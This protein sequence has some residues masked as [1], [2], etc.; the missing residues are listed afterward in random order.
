MSDFQSSEQVGQEIQPF[1]GT[2]QQDVGA[3]QPTQVP[4]AMS[5]SAPA[6]PSKSAVA[7][8][9]SQPQPQP[10]AQASSQGAPPQQ[11]IY[12]TQQVQQGAPSV[13]VLAPPKSVMTALVLTFFFGPLGMFYSTVVG[14]IVMI[15]AAIVIGALTLGMGLFLIWPVSM[16]W[17]ALA[18]SNANKLAMANV[19]M[20]QNAPR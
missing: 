9:Q 18:A 14:A 8:P 15:I 6:E 17:G 20:T 19:T 3:S 5:S 1:A 16:V 13:V 12:I 2:P 4:N 10:Q 11:N 7:E